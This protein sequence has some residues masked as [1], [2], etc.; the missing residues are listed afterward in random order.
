MAND[1]QPTPPLPPVDPAEL[2]RVARGLV[3]PPP[4]GGWPWQKKP[5]DKKEGDG[6]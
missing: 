1:K 2:E 3:R 5:K 6:A 4:P